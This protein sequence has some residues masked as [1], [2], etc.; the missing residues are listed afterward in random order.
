M[1][2][3]AISPR[4]GL[5]YLWLKEPTGRQEFALA[6]G[7]PLAI[8]EA[9]SS[10]LV[11][12]SPVQ[13]Q[14]LN[15]S[16]RDRILATVF[17]HC[18][19][20]A[21]E[22][23]LKCAQCEKPFELGFSLGEFLEELATPEHATPEEATLVP[24]NQG[25]FTLNPGVKFRLP[26]VRDEIESADLSPDSAAVYLMERCLVEGCI[27]KDA[28]VVEDAMQRLAPLL[29]TELSSNCPHCGQSHRVDF[30]LMSFSQRCFERDIAMLSREI[31]C[32][33][34]AYRFGYE[35]ILDMPRSVRQRLTSLL[36]GQ[37]TA[38]AA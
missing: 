14:H 6:E 18:F 15:L 25:I 20:D 3:V 33:A 10:L 23:V 16:D 28:S 4:F 27:E 30:D 32:L 1:L 31:H 19:G 12:I 11:S 29:R 5:R 7:H 26:T 2:K 21:V 34:S 8:A 17:S 37:R 36:L 24:N 22:T 13:F 9:L 38:G 35:E